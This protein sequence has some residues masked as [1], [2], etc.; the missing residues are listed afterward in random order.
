MKNS[1]PLLFAVLVFA[2]NSRDVTPANNKGRLNFICKK[3]NKSFLR[4]LRKLGGL[5]REFHRSGQA[6][7]LV[8]LFCF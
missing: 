6:Y 4:E 1:G 5:D 7:L 2:G 8:M 3:Q